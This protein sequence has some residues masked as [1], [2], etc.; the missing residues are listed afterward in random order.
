[1]RLVTRQFLFSA[2]RRGVTTMITRTSRPRVGVSLFANGNLRFFG[3]ARE[4][5]QLKTIFTVPR[6]DKSITQSFVLSGGKGGQNV[7]KVNTKVQLFFKVD[8]AD[9]LP[10]EVKQRLKRV[11]KN[12]LNKEGEIIVSSSATRSQHT[13]VID[14]YQK[15]QMLVDAASVI[16]K[17]V[18][19]KDQPSKLSKKK[20]IEKKR[21]RSEVKK[22]RG[23]G[24][25]FDDF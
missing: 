21:R 10:D 9:F 23:R 7:N 24:R 5:N 4:R 15:L 20:M 2:I 3:R 25:N 14:A 12:I 13:N 11:A 8:E 22:G 6:K 18:K 1:M 17:E 19:I 16:P